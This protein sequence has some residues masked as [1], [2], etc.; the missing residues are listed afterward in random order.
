MA[1]ITPD[2]DRIVYLSESD[3]LSASGFAQVLRDRWFS[4]HPERG[5]MFWQTERGRKGKLRG[6]APQCNSDEAT[7]RILAAKMY[8]WA[9]T[10]FYPLVLLPIDLND[11]RD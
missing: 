6:A 8:P 7:A 10:R 11:Y 4:V 1:E 3:L 9:E 2:D 5:L